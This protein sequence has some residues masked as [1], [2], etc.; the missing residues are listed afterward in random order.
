LRL[1]QIILGVSGGER[2]ET[3]VV[4]PKPRG[5]TRAPIDAELIAPELAARAVRETIFRPDRETAKA[6]VP[7][8]R[9]TAQSE[10]VRLEIADDALTQTRMLTESRPGGVPLVLEVSTASADD[11]DDERMDA[12]LRRIAAAAGVEDPS[13]FGALLAQEQIE[14]AEAS[15]DAERA[16]VE[17]HR[18]ATA[19]ALEVRSIDDRMTASVVPD[20]LWIATAFGGAGVFMTV[21]ALLYPQLRIYVVP[22]MTAIALIGFAAYGLRSLRELK[23]R[24]ALL[25][26]R[27]EMRARRET[28]RR[29]VRERADALVKMGVDPDRILAHLAGARME[30]PAIIGRD[31]IVDP[32]ADSAGDRQ[33]VI[34]C[35][36]T[37]ISAQTQLGEE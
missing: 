16:Y 12:L 13:L 30:V 5:R 15:S 28:A 19:L 24:G 21:I 22:I 7:F 3:I 14:G 9:V 33:I 6:E 29:E 2:R 35:R 36:G 31:A 25:I 17:A 27:R 32:N 23:I 18:R 26:E 11:R 20:W 10:D 8:V 4:E 34:F 37:P 1:E